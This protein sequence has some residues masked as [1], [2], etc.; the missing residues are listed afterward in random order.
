[1]K[2]A[3]VILFVAFLGGFLLLNAVLPDKTF[4]DMENRNLAGKPALT[5]ES[6]FSG[7][8]ESDA[9]SYVTDQFAFRDG[10][11][12]LKA[13]AERLLGKRENN[14]VYICTDT[15]IE[16]IDAPDEDRLA[17]NLSA[18]NR[19][20]EN[21][22]VPV[23]FT[24]IPSAAEIWQDKLPSGAP[25]C[26]E[27]AVIDNLSAETTAIYVDTLSALSEHSDESL[28]YRTDHHWTS[29]GALYGAQALVD[30][31]G[32]NYSCAADY[33]PVCVTDAFY[34]TLYS[35]SGARYIQPDSIDVYVPSDG[36]TVTHIEG[37]EKTVTGLYDEEKLTL[38][39][40]YAFFM[41]G[42]QPLAVV[43]T[44]REGQKLLL[45]RDSYADCEIPFLCGAFSEIHVIDLRY[46][47]ESLSAYIEDNDIDCVVISYSLR[48]FISDTNL[49]FLNR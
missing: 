44:G 45:I 4:S 14:G 5:F 6:V 21:C 22:T 27:R 11:I 10:W 40:K 34:G 9:E 18:V 36:I 38:K 32:I 15:L 3:L 2:K 41:G 39:D 24:L 28:Y 8:F 48:S 12:A 13:Y 31:M 35:S 42:N 46:Y 23:Y 43:Q 17:S 1:M 37:D 25:R 16:R 49:F 7:A 20:A 47:H 33:E 19:F 30:G 29:L 26:D